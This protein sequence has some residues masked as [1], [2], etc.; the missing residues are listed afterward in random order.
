MYCPN[1]SALCFTIIFIIV[2]V[3]GAASLPVNDADPN[4]DGKGKFLSEF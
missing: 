2:S 4:S 1:K 3:I